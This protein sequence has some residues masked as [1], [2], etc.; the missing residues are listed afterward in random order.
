VTKLV[1]GDIF[2]AS[3]QQARERFAS[4]ETKAALPELKDVQFFMADFVGRSKEH[5]LQQGNAAIDQLGPFD[6]VTT[7]KAMHY[8]GRRSEIEATFARYFQLLRDGGS[9]LAVI[10]NPFD[11]HGSTIDPAGP[12]GETGLHNSRHEAFL[13]HKTIHA[14]PSDDPDMAPRQVHYVQW[15]AEATAPL[16][17]Q[18]PLFPASVWEEAASKA[19]FEP[20]VWHQLRATPEVEQQLGT[21]F[22][23]PIYEHC[24]IIGFTARKPLL[25]LL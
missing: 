6:L 17:F 22:F 12:T 3:I 16:S 15:S 14:L 19:G 7:V 20:L 4:A 2:E 23:A 9:V 25:S 24:P 18:Q 5:A 10:T 1:G 11:L 13:F 8:L 21:A